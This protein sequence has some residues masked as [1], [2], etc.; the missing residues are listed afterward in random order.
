MSDTGHSNPDRELLGQGLANLATPLF[1][2]M[3]A[4]G[5]IARTAVNV[6]A[7]ARTRV[8]AIVHS[9]VLLA[10]VYLAGPLVAAI[11]VAA[12]AGVLMVTAIRMIEPHNLRAVLGSTRSDAAILIV[13]AVA[14][15]AFDLIVAVEV[16]IAVAAFLA[17]RQ[18]TRTS[19]ATPAPANVT[20]APGDAES[21]I[22]ADTEA[23]LLSEHI[24]VYQLEGA[25]F[26]G[27]A[28]HFLTILTDIADVEVVILR[29]PK[30]QFLDA[31]GA[32]TLGEIVTQ[33][34]ARH[35]TVLLKSSRPEHT[36]ILSAVGALDRLASHHHIF[37]NLDDAIEHA[38]QHVLRSHAPHS[39]SGLRE[40]I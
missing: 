6:R 12:L 16:G 10:V 32:H 27:A 28:Q 22:D 25:L 40:P 30:L 4:T 24:V 39:A 11:P 31:T 33:L 21:A 18:L 2:G 14:T 17:L 36:K 26:F 20:A 5:A 23:E 3:P 13:T 38:H 35:I 1:G 15:V 37:D 9:L 34:E 29:L 7:G 19:T 8:A